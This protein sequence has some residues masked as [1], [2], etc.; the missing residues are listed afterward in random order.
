MNDALL[1]VLMSL[2]TYRGTRLATTDTIFDRPRD[3]VRWFFENRFMRKQSEEKIRELGDSDEWHSKLAYFV[4]CPWCASIWV[5]GLVTLATM[6]TVG[7]PY[8]LLVWPATSAVTGLLA[9]W[10]GD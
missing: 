5:G 2:T 6:L 8:P 7:V 10:E 1:V 4:G 9:S 3:A